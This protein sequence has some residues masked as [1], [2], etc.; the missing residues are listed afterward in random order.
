MVIMVENKFVPKYSTSLVKQVTDF[1]TNEVIGSE[2]KGGERLVESELQRKFGISRGPIREAFRI[3]EKNGLLVTVPRKGTFVRTITGDYIQEI[4]P[5]RANLESL[6]ARL[7]ISHMGPEYIKRMKL[8]LT[9]MIES[10]QKRNLKSY[11][12]QH[13]EFH[14]IFIDASKNNTLIELL[15]NL[16]RQSIWFLF[17]SFYDQEHYEYSIDEHSEILECFIKK[18]ANRVEALVRDH[19]MTSYNKFLP[20]WQA[21]NKKS[22]KVIQK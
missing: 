15:E 16:R 14:Q 5:I 11:V 17:S 18:D 21:K 9:G 19:I 13:F 4:F 22:F 2:L 6:A 12:K 8:M 3:L 1:L 20:F 10:A 7:A